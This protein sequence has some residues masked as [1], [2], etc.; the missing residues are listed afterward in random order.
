MKVKSI[1]AGYHTVTPWIIVR[2]AAKLLDYV[3]E[4][5][6]ADNETRVY[7]ED[8]TIGH[9]EVRIG[10][11]VIMMFDAKEGWPP[12]PSFIRLFVED[13]DAV[14]QQALKAGGTSVTEMTELF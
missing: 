6:G 9:A 10:D 11:S 5:F 14:Y 12:T 3:K 2:G 13:G 8:G 1:P 4:A 7:N